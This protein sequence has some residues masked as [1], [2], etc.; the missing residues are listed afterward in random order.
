VYRKWVSIVVP[1]IMIL[2]LFEGDLRARLSV[3]RKHRLTVAVLLFVGFNAVSLLWSPHPRDGFAY[4]DKYRYLLLIPV[5]ATSLTARFAWAARRALLAGTGVS[6]ALSYAVF[7][8]FFEIGGAYERNPAVT[9]SHL[10][11]SMVLAVVGILLVHHIVST[12][13]SS[14]SRLMWLSCLVVV[15]GGLAVNIGRSGQAAFVGAFLVVLPF[16]AAV[17]SRRRVALELVAA[18][19]LTL[20]AAYLAVPGLRTRVGMAATGLDDAV[21]GQSY[22]TSVGKRVAGTVVAVDM[23]RERPVLGTGAG[24]NMPEFR[25]LL[26]TRHR[27]LKPF[28][29]WFPHLHN[30]YLQVVTE[31][32]LTG[33]GLLLYLM[34]CLIRGPYSNPDDRLAAIGIAAVYLIGFLGDPYLH[35]QLPLVM[36]AT[37]AGMLSA[38]GR[39]GWW[40]SNEA[41]PQR[42]Q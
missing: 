9:M 38:N 26:D 17:R 12:E 15:V 4:V 16:H 6:L 35:K 14:R 22:E 1:L 39:S 32:G 10:D 34:Y 40:D 23:V 11:Y 20:A 41:L 8:G 5:I 28:I 30:Q 36:F 42:P 3:L 19:L 21:A 7:F 27:D 24:G 37:V 18:M 33:L 29:Y 13:M 25:R 2:W 31:V